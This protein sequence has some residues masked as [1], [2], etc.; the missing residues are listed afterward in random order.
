VCPVVLDVKAEE[1]EEGEEE[2]EEDDDEEEEIAESDGAVPT[3]E[4]PVGAGVVVSPLGNPRA[5]PFSR[6][7]DSV[8]GISGWRH[9]GHELWCSSHG[10]MQD[11]WKIWP[12]GRTLAEV[13]LSLQIA[14]SS[15]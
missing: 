6:R 5:S 8:L 4:V 14:Q 3:V 12:H 2:G 9:L 7:L 11:K 15:S 10:R 13:I 1:V